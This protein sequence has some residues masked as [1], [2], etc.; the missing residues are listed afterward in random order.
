MLSFE[1]IDGGMA[2]DFGRT[3]A[4]YAKYRDIYPPS[5]YRKLIEL[6]IAAPGLEIL[7]I[8]TGTGVLPRN[9]LN[10]GACFTGCDIS[11]GQI[12]MAEQISPSERIKYVV[13]PAENTP[14]ADHSFDVVTA[15]QCFNYF[16]QA[17]LAAELLRILKPGGRF[18]KIYMSWLPH[19][20]DIARATEQLV[21]QYNPKWN[22]GGFTPE[23]FA[24]PEWSK[25]NFGL[26]TYH[27]YRENLPF[28]AETWCGRMRSCRG[29]GASLPSAEAEAFEK[30]LHQLL[31]ERG[32]DGNFSI[33]HYIEIEAYQLKKQ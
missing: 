31:L 12:A 7:D 30:E 14:F 4:D 19:E 28:T 26:E 22:G 15:C 11:P 23:P 32:G 27:F 24:V 5:M 3:S 25:S 10:S 13:C 20:D 9:L 16:D 17:K 29:I 2:F 1:H 8:A 21:L 6:G 18:C 33:L